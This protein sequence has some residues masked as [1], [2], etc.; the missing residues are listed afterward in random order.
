MCVEWFLQRYGFSDVN[1]PQ[2]GSWFSRSEKLYPVHVAAMLGD[3]DMLHFLLEAGA[4]PEQ[5]TSKGRSALECA[6]DANLDGSHH[7]IFDLLQS[8]PERN[9]SEADLVFV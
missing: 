7:C 8:V 1:K 5:R 3:A 2:R 4:D 6:F 9:C